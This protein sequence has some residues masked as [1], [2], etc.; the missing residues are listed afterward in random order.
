MEEETNSAIGSNKYF[1]VLIISEEGLH[2]SQINKQRENHVNT[3]ITSMN[4]VLQT[5]NVIFQ[6]ATLTESFSIEQCCSK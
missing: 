3:G 1:A 6:G 4:S 5:E 2:L